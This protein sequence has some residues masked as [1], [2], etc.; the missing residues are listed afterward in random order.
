MAL[1][2]LAPETRNLID[3]V[4]C[5]AS[6]GNR[7]ENLNPSTGEVLGHAADGTKDDMLRPVSVARRAVD[8]SDWSEN[9]ELR[10]KCGSTTTPGTSASPSMSCPRNIIR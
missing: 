6:N 2:D 7:F 9:A 1:S 5:D 3:G 4:L 10:S 8:E